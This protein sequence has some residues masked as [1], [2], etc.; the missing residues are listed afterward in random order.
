MLCSARLVLCATLGLLAACAEG[1]GVGGGDTGGSGGET[2]SDGGFGPGPSTSTASTTPTG[3]SNEGGSSE[4]GAPPVGG[5]GEGGSGTAC[6][7]TAPEV[8]DGA[9]PLP[10]IAGDE[11]GAP[12]T[13]NGH[14]S[15]WFKIHVEEQ[16]SGIF[17]ADISYTVSLTSPPGA[18]YA[19]H[20]YQAAQD[21][22]PNCNATVKNGTG[23]PPSVHDS[24]DD[25]QPIGGEN[26][27]TW[28]IIEVAH[29]SGEACS[30]SDNWTLTVTGNT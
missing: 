14:T 12:V 13:R 3:G 19:L 17:D 21:S 7:F 30:S 9:E 4:G 16:D 2:T 24:W 18:V 26:D 22:P 23:N 8:C 11:D 29:V 20:V 15:K 10:A 27:S 6:D 25:D 28:V 5:S 1:G